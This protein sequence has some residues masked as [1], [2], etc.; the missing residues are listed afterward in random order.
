MYIETSKMYQKLLDKE[1]GLLIRDVVSLCLS[2]LLIILILLIKLTLVPILLLIIST[3]YFSISCIRLFYRIKQCKRYDRLYKKSC[4]KE[5][6]KLKECPYFIDS[7]GT[8]Y[9]QP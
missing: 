3:L 1:T 6:E 8:Q 5:E 9:F 7:D 2:V 4:K